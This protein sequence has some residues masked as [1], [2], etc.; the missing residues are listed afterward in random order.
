MSDNK[1]ADATDSQQRTT[2]FG[3][4]K[5]KIEILGDII[6]P[7][8]IEREAAIDRDG[9]RVTGREASDKADASK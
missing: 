1:A 6:E 9:S 4:D 5:G 7:L 8:Y 3:I 2:L